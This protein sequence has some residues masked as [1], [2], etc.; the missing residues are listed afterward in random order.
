M[1]WQYSYL[2]NVY[3]VDLS[4]TLR[5][6]SIGCHTHDGCINSLIHADDMVLLTPSADA[7]QDLINVCQVYAAKY[8]IVYDNDNDNNN[9][10]NN[11]NNNGNNNYNNNGNNDN[12]NNNNNNSNNNNDNINNNNNNNN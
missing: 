11:D 8:G 3:T 1:K 12:N 10:N 5:D 6:T 2:C 7:L 9:G 4:A